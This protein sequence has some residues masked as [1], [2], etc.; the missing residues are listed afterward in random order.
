MIDENKP[1]I[2]LEQF[3]NDIVNDRVKVDL[4]EGSV[5]HYLLV[6]I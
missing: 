6:K 4:N 1:K 2:T 5:T 3:V